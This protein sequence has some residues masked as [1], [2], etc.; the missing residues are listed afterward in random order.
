MSTSDKFPHGIGNARDNV[1]R[2]LCDH[3]AIGVTFD[4]DEEIWPGRGPVSPC[5]IGQFR[6]GEF[7]REHAPFRLDISNASQVAAVTKEV[8]EEGYFGKKPVSRF[9]FVRPAD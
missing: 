4:V 5:S 7:R 2:N 3:P 9:V 1:G 6:D 8:L